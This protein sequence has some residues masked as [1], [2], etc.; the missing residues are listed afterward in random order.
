MK[1]RHPQPKDQ[2]LIIGAETESTEPWV[3]FNQAAWDE[4]AAQGNPLARPAEDHLFANPLQCVDG[5][6]WLGDSI[7]GQKVL[8]LAAGGGRQG[9]LYA[10]AGGQVTVVDISG[11]M[12]QMDRQVAAERKLD[13][14]TVQSSMEHMPMFGEGVFDLVIHPVSTCYVP[15]LTHVYRE[16]ARVLRSGGLYISQHKQPASLQTELKPDG[17]GYTLREEYYRQTALPVFDGK[18]PLREAGAQEFIHRWEQIVGWMCRAGFVIEDLLE[19]MH[20]KLSAAT[21]S[22]GHRSRFVAPYVRIK[23]RRH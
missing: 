7:R 12:L 5:P 2:G 8:C 14:E 21:G 11:G 23:A 17:A 1:D 6:G 18:S 4:L 22:L 16:I 15:D 3:D 9:P 13:I 20:A 10:A 19:P